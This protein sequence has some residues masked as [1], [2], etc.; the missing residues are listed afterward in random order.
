MADGGTWSGAHGE[1]CPVA[2]KEAALWGGAGPRGP[3]CLSGCPHRSRP[4][5]P[6]AEVFFRRAACPMTIH[7][8]REPDFTI[9]GM[10]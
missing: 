2:R 6:V 10:S 8:A 5:N 3:S 1:R 7:V 9:P 4:A